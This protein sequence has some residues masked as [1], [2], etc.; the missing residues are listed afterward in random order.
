LAKRAAMFAKPII[1]ITPKP[2]AVAR[3]VSGA[4][5]I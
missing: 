2:T 3:L 1:T 4:C 5:T